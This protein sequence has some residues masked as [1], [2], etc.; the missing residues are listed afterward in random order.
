MP[1]GVTNQTTE[2]RFILGVTF[3]DKFK[4]GNLKEMYEAG[5]LLS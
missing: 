1:H 5:E 2:D 3:H 4:V